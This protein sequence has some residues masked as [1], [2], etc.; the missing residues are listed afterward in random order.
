[1][2]GSGQGKWT[3]FSMVLP[4]SANNNANVKIGFLWVNDDDGA[5]TDPS[6]AVDDVTLTDA[7]TASNPVVSITPSPSA[8][9]CVTSTLTLNGSATNGPITSYSWTVIPATGATFIPNV[10]TPTVA[11][12]FSV[13]GTYT[14]D[15]AATNAS[16]TG[17][18]TQVITVTPV[19]ASSVSVTA[20]PS[21]P[22]CPGTVVSFTATPT[23]AGINPTYQWQVNGVNGGTNLPTFTPAA[24][25]NN[26]VVNVTL[27]P[28]ATCTSPSTA[29][30]TVQ[31]SSAITPTVTILANPTGT[32]CPGTIITFNASTLGSGANPAYQWQVNGINAGTNSST[33]VA[34]V[35]VNNAVVTV[36]VTPIASCA[37]AA[38]SSYTVQVGI[39]VTPSVTISVSPSATVCT[40]SVATFSATSSNGGTTPVFQWI[41]N[42]INSGTNSATYTLIP[43]NN[44]QV[45]VI[46]TSNAACAL[47]LIANSNTITIT[48]FS[49]SSIVAGLTKTICSGDSTKLSSTGTNWVWSPSTGLSC[50]NCQYPKASPSATTIYTVTASSGACTSSATQTVVVN[51][52]ATALFGTTGLIIPGIPQTIN[53]ANISL[54]ANGYSWNFGDNSGNIIATNPAHTYNAAGTY[55]VTLI[56]YSAN[57]CNDT[58]NSLLSVTDTAG[59]TM[60][61]V[62]TPNGDG[63]N[64]Y[65]IPNAHGLKTL[66]CTI[67]DR[68]GVKITDLDLSTQQYWDGHTTAGLACSDGTYFYTLKATDVNG[69]SYSLKGFIQLIR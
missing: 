36:T 14:F 54:N 5:G 9:I 43:S 32:V 6:F 41:K 2:C 3:A 35:L 66:D 10:T 1:L 59:L 22:I 4:A 68:W 7:A 11:V 51:Q 23:N 49:G 33:F 34:P 61:N 62:F 12:T 57:G 42:G 20:S 55:T 39:N 31:V 8:T 28:T 29:S 58:T 40:G 37:S 50:V 24:L 18:M 60:P 67:Y 25:V 44:D 30:Y 38:S 46:M 19:I 56:A 53:F 17:N 13:A 21:N 64:D 48:V 47:P 65:F 69:K 27:T 26:D 15:L 16:G 45:H 63:I 52:S